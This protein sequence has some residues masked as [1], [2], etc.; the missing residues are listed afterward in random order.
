MLKIWS[1]GK[2]SAKFSVILYSSCFQCGISHVFLYSSCISCDT[3]MLF[4]C[5]FMHSLY[6]VCDAVPDDLAVDE[7]EDEDQLT[8]KRQRTNSNQWYMIDCTCTRQVMC[9]LC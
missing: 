4:T 1:A 9:V 7:V 8:S 5:V 2:V 3:C 6:S